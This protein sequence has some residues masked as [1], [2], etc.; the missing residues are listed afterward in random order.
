MK[1]VGCKYMFHRIAQ[2]PSG[3]LSE[4]ILTRNDL[5]G[6]CG[7]LHIIQEGRRFW[8]GQVFEPAFKSVSYVGG[9]SYFIEIQNTYCKY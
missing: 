9:G 2:A 3:I 5:Q 8:E 6:A 1:R 7:Q 4:K